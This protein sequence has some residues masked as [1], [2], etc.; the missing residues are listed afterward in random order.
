MVKDHP[1]KKKPYTVMIISLDMTYLDT[2]IINM[3]M[4]R[5]DDSLNINEEMED[6]A[7]SI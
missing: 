1:L 4:L 2:I 7:I 3:T 5:V 6:V